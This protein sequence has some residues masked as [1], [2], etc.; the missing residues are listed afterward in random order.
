MGD[1]MYTIRGIIPNLPGGFIWSFLAEV[2]TLEIARAHAQVFREEGLIVEIRDPSGKI[3]S[4][5]DE[6]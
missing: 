3:L 5:Q 4:E 1:L 2:E 6:K